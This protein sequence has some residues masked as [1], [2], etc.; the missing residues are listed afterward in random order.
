MFK[1]KGSEDKN[2]VKL[3]S[4]LSKY[5]SIFSNHPGE[6]KGTPCKLKIKE[7]VNPIIC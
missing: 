4:I 7:N 1:G 6:I 3:Q 5:K 2:M